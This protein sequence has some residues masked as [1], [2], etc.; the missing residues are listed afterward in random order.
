MAINKDV[1]EDLPYSLSNPLSS[2]SFVATAEDYDVAFAGQP[3]FLAISDA[4]PYRRQTAPY[5]KQQIDQSNEPGEQ[6]L[7]NW[8]LRSQSSF[9]KGSGITYYDPSSGEL[10]PYRFAD[11]KGV[12][13]WTKG[14][15]SLLKTTANV[16]YTTGTLRAN[17]R[18]AQYLRSITYSGT[19][20]VLLSDDYDIEKISD[21]GRVSFVDYTAGTDTPVFGLCDDGTYAYW[22][23]NS[24]ASNSKLTVNKKILTGDVGTAETTM[25]QQNGVVVTNAVM[26]FVKERIVMCANNSVYEFA[27][28]ASSMPT[29]VYTHPNTDYV[30]TSITASGPAIYVSGYNGIK[31]VIHKFTL[32]TAGAMPT[33]TSAITAAEMPEGEIVYKIFYYLGYMMIGTS[34]GVRAAIVSDQDGSINYGPLIFETS[35]P[36]YDFAARDKFVWCSTVVG[37]D[38]GLIRINLGEQIETLRFAYANDI[39]YV[40]GS[41]Y[42]ATGTALLGKTSRMVFCTNAKSSATED[43]GFNAIESASTLVSS[44]YVQ[45]GNIRFATV[46]DK[47][48]KTIHTNIDNTNGGLKV[49][50]I[51]KTGQSYVIA[52]FSAG[53]IVQDASVTYPQGKQ[54]YMAYRFTIDNTGA[55][56]T[57]KGTVF[58][59]YQ[60]KA[61]PAIARQRFIQFPVFCYDQEKDKFG[62]EVGYEGRAFARMQALEAT[63]SAGDTI[64]VQDFRTGET[65]L[66]IIEELNFVNLTPAGQRFS[67]YGG[68]LLI[69]IRTVS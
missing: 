69:T 20:A 53:D 26:E 7:S 61:L 3:F 31:S 59:G 46:E 6:S 15:V 21:A 63:E 38:P 17:G 42:Y 66:G 50:S 24:A 32:S 48:F 27:S 65:V 23:T 39:Y 25:F 29:A 37:T 5:R 41:G 8:W 4:Y 60:L 67:G 36:V 55:G 9:H 68:V 1:T 64:R 19:D 12:D 44:G 54:E 11:S 51:S 40:G 62:N 14:K 16:H 22:V 56:G 34:K 18:P 52:R 10:V 2:V 33:L 58:S 30:F 57:S 47:V 13:V 49:E 43:R 28:T 35:Q 45:T